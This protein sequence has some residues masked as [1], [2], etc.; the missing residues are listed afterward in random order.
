R[1]SPRGQKYAGCLERQPAEHQHLQFA[2]IYSPRE[3][4][5]VADVGHAGEVHDAALKAKAESSVAGGAVFAQI[6]VEFVIF[7]AKSQ[8]IH[9]GQQLLVVVLPLAAADDL[10]DAGHQAVHGSD[11]LPVIVLLHV[12]GLDLL[13]VVGDEHRALEDLLREVALVLRLEIAAPKYLVVKLVVVLL[14]N[15]HGLR[16]GDMAE[17]RIQHAV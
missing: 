15:L 6:Q 9:A 13:G 8:F 3:R 11:G 14:Q 7:R 17:L 2:V 1:G 16:V 4:D 10:S 5:Y 12:E